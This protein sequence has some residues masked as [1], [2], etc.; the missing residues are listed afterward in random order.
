MKVFYSL[1]GLRRLNNAV[2]ALGVFDGIHRAH[3]RILREAAA[4]AKRIRGTSVCLTFWPH[5]QAQRS[6]YS[7]EHRLRLIAQQGIDICVVISFTDS[8]A[9]I[10]AR[11]F[12][13]RL[14]IE[15]IGGR[16]IYVGEN[17]RFGYK[18][19]GDKKLLEQLSRQYLFGLKTFKV[20]RVNKRPVSST[21]I[22]RLISR[23]KLK[24]AARLLGRPVSI[25]GT[26]VGGS[27]VGRLLGFPT[28]NIN[29][30]HEVVPPQGVYAVKVLLAKNNFGGACYIGPKPAFSLRKNAPG[31]NE[32]I[33]VH[34]FGFNKNI[35][36]ENLEVQF[37]KKIRDKKIFYSPAKLAL[38]IK[39]DIIATL[40]IFSSP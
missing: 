1:K 4:K 12:I 9:R 20:I 29:P 40:R 10:S 18:K 14:V 3:Q 19:Q 26:V 31:K 28:A 32:N 15:K 24:E 27:A 8:F 22:R 7:L 36:G 17:F 5:P 21:Y 37:I 23:G 30:H 25:F 39:K 6:L 34:I 35:Y 2:V 38:Q 11:D 16:H 33:E 13:R